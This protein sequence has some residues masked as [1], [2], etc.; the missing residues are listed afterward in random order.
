MKVD[1]NN[2]PAG[3]EAIVKNLFDTTNNVYIRD[4]YKR[5]LMNIRDYCDDVVKF[6]DNKQ[7]QED[8]AK[9]KKRK[10]M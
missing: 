6:Y 8:L 3:V 1:K 7:A 5:T 10:I 4:N 2:I 9:T